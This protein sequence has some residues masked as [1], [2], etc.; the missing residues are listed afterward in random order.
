[1]GDFYE[2]VISMNYHV[3]LRFGIDNY[4]LKSVFKIYTYLVSFIY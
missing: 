2:L 4:S 1:M 3:K